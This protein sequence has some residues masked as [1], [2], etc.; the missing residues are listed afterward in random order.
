PILAALLALRAPIE[1]TAETEDASAACGCLGDY[2]LL[3][4]V[5]R[6]GMGVVYEAEQISLGR[7]VALKVL[8]FA[9]T[10]DPRQLQR[11][12]HEAQAAAMLH[13]PHVVPVFG[14]GCERGVHYYALQIIEGRSLASVIE[15]MRGEVVDRFAHGV[16]ET[17]PYQPPADAVAGLSEA[18]RLYPTDPQPGSLTP[19]TE[20]PKADTAL[21]AALS[22]KATRKDK[23]HYRRIAELI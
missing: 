23:A 11:F 3:R 8:P 20:D 18:G 16:N 12:R 13:H 19:A 21:I 17:A 5:G 9:A 22:T 7:H 4:E 15:E 1:A 14:V 6:G 2:R 10:M